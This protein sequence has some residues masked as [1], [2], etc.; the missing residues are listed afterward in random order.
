MNFST[1]EN[2]SRNA[3]YN[4]LRKSLG[5]PKNALIRKSFFE[6]FFELVDDTTYSPKKPEGFIAS[7]LSK[8]GIKELNLTAQKL[9]EANKLEAA[10]GVEAEIFSITIDALSVVA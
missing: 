10:K 5:L 9:R 6:L 2:Y 3:A 4:L 8:K 7:L 1:V